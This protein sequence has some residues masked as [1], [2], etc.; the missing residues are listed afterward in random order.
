MY[1]SAPTT[2][3]IPSTPSSLLPP[4]RSA[5]QEKDDSGPYKMHMVARMEELQRGEQVVPPCDR[6]RRLHMDCLKNLTACMGCTKK[7]AKCSWKDVR[8]EELRGVEALRVSRDR[9][10][11]HHPA[12]QPTPVQAAPTLAPSF[13]SVPAPAPA[14]PA[15]E[16]E[17]LYEEFEPERP[18]R[19]YRPEGWGYDGRRE[20]A[21]VPGQTLANEVSPRRAKSE[22]Q[23]SAAFHSERRVSSNRN[24]E[25][26]AD[27][28]DPGANQRLMQAILD[29]VDHHSRATAPSTESSKEVSNEREHEHTMVRA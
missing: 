29:T 22:N 1:T 16:P 25:A 26:G 7:H 12:D 2:V 21:P 10:E 20:S 24:A 15:Q 8:E 11:D 27:D 23:S 6:C 9:A 17:R 28:D 13:A 4:P 5:Q 14:P 19:E 18:Y 3:P